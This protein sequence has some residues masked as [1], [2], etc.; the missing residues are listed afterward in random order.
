MGPPVRVGVLALQGDFREHL[1][2]LRRLEVPA[3]EVRTVEDLEAVDAL[4]LPG[5]EST[6]IARLMAKSGLD[7]VI[8]KR[9][10]AGMPLYGTC[11]GLILLAKELVE[12]RP[13]PL[14]LLDVTVDRN[15]YGRQ[16]DSFEADI[17]IKSM[18]PFHAVFIR[19][20]KITRCG[21]SV[22]ILAE[23]DGAPVLVRQGNLLGSSFHPEL[24][25]DTRIHE[26]FLSFLGKP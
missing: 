3:Q 25:D 24:T 21:P 19:A 1:A 12:D 7:R 9:G 26:F 17:H 20:P 18:G 22:E 6:T 15:A 10:E 8:K 11:A 5:G 2:V 16:V 4:I 14:G 13:Q 23:H